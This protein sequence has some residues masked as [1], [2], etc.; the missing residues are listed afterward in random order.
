MSFV[1]SSVS[2]FL[3]RIPFFAP[4]PLHTM[5]AVGVASHRAQGQ[6]ITRQAIAGARELSISHP[7]SIIHVINVRREITRIVGT[8][9]LETLSAIF[10]IGAFEF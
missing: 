8:K 2:A 10:S 5:I 9:M 3:I 1:F 7:V 6:A 4:T